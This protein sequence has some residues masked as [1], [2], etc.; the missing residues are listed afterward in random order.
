LSCFSIDDVIS[1]LIANSSDTDIK[2]QWE[3][4]K[5][6]FT[7]W[8]LSKKVE[9]V[10]VGQMLD[11]RDTG[12]IWCK[13]T[14]TMVIE[15]IGKEPILAIH[16]EGWNR[17]YDEFLSISSPRLARLGF[18]T[19]RD[20]IPKYK[21]K[22]V[23]GGSKNQMQAFIVNR[24][25]P[26]TSKLAT[27]GKKDDKKKTPTEVARMSDDDKRRYENSTMGDNIDEKLDDFFTKY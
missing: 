7:T 23:V 14:V 5:C 4:Q 17:W 19:I 3:N 20:D 26:P 1:Q 24:I 21:M 15:S 9:K 2:V 22:P 10:D 16:Y 6:D 12:Y 18:Y 8:Q 27:H 25:T 13:G 11:V